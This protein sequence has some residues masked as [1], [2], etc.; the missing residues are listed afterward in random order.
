MLKKVEQIQINSILTYLRKDI[1][2]CVYMYIDIAKY[3]IENPNME[4][5][6]DTGSHEICLVV[7]RYYN[8]ISM[9]S[10]QDEWDIDAVA[11]LIRSYRVGMVSGKKSMIEKLIVQCNDLYD[12][13]YGYVFQLNQYRDFK[14]PDDLIEDGTAEDVLEIATL[15][16]SNESIGGYYKIENLAMQLKERIETGIGRSLIIRRNQKIVAHIATYAEYEKIGV[17]A[18]LIAQQDSAGIPYGTILESRL[19]HDLLKEGFDIYTFVTEKKRAMFFNLMGC[20]ELGRYGKMILK[21]SDT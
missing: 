17:T 7:M 20:I 2:N 13:E 9:Y 8:S 15:I 1:G 4:L 19:V 16:C 14:I 11:E 21:E 5:W 10:D 18:G 12:I 6:C 3:G